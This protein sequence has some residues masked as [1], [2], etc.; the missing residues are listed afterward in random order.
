[1]LY[2]RNFFSWRTLVETLVAFRVQNKESNFPWFPYCDK[3]STV[4]DSSVPFIILLLFSLLPAVSAD[5]VKTTRVHSHFVHKYNF[6]TFIPCMSATASSRVSNNITPDIQYQI[7]SHSLC[8][9]TTIIWIIEDSC[10]YLHEEPFYKCENKVFWS[11]NHYFCKHIHD[12]R[13][14]D[15]MHITS[16]DVEATVMLV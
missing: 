6:H 15:K 4:S 14:M 16:T 5:R 11:S 13:V 3:S 1:M 12:A 2:A 9:L 10:A 7:I 8:D